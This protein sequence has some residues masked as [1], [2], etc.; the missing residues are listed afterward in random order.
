ML[1]VTPSGTN[2]TMSWPAV[3]GNLALE[4]AVNVTGPWV[5]IANPAA[6]GGQYVYVLPGTNGYHFFRLI[7]Q[8]H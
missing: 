1:T 8:M 2:Y 5:P 6:V 4:G 7:S 3:A